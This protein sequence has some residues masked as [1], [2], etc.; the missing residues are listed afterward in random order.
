MNNCEMY[1][2]IY[3]RFHMRLL[4]SHLFPDYELSKSRILYKFRS[5]KLILQ[6]VF[7]PRYVCFVL[8]KSVFHMRNIVHITVISIKVSVIASVL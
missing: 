1:E 4:V 6:F 3:S 2:T 7:C 8:L 5:T